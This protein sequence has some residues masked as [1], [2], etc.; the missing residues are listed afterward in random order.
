MQNSY[1]NNLKVLDISQGVAGPFGAKLLGDLGADVVKIEPPGGDVSRQYGPFPGGKAD[2]EQSAS[3]FFFNTSK[4]GMVLDIDSANGKDTLARLVTEYDVIIAGESEEVL[5]R[6]GLSYADFCRWNPNIILT[7]V[8]GFGSFGPHSGYQ[9][10]HLVASA[11]GGWSTLCGVPDREPLQTGGA[12]SETLAG[13]FA[14]V[15]TSMAVLG[16]YAHGRGEHVDVSVQE[17]VLAC[18]SFPTL[19][20]EYHGFTRDRYSSVGGG[21]GACYMIPTREGYI[22]LN[23]LTVAQWRMLCRFLG[24]EDIITDPH[25][26][27]VSW[28]RPDERLEEIREAFG[29]AV[30]DRT[31]EEL[32]H[33]AQ[34]H[35]VPFG[36]VPDL[37]K[38]FT[39]PPFVERGFFQKISHPVTGPVTIPGIPFNVSGRDDKIRIRRPPLLGEHHDE[40]LNALKAA[41]TVSENPRSDYPNPLPLK[42]LRVIDLSMFFAGPVCTQILADAGADVIKVESVQR[43]DGWRGSVPPPGSTAPAWESAPHFNWVNR[44]KRGITL[45]LTDP[46]GTE[47]LKRL[48]R[49]ADVVI[50]N[51][52]PRVMDKFGLG[53][54]I[55]REIKPDIIMI[56]LPGF[57]SDVT[58]RDYV[59][60]GMST[61]QMSG[62]AHLTGYNDDGPLFTG[63][64][65]GDIY[66]GAMGAHL[67]LAALHDRRT[68]G[69]G[70]HINLSQAEACNLYVGDAM[71]GYSLT[72]V[73][74]GRRGNSHTLFA[75]QGIYPCRN[76]RWI[77]ISCLT[78]GQWRS[79][80]D[81]INAELV[82]RFPDVKARQT[83]ELDDI[84]RDWTLG[85]D[86]DALMSDLQ[87]LG[88]A[89]GIVQNGPDLLA[90]PQLAT[91]GSLLVQDRPGIGEKHYPNQPY[92][93]RNAMAPPNE[94]APLLGEHCVEV[95]TSVAGVSDEELGE[96]F[97]DD[98]IGMDPVASR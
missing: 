20:Y 31:A 30:K 93:F 45:N 38:V 77:G 24:R 41:P 67:V 82:A 34:S 14:A 37:A 85:H 8:S 19:T 47:I 35:R 90:D 97:I 50:E 33:E 69:T 22:G 58:W 76:D 49:D 59:A 21:A 7:T 68:T 95:L 66:S 88:I 60:F 32:F 62:L 79:L 53:F 15:A 56:S 28:N 74:P 44:N 10:S 3:F 72:G 80:A 96:L 11:M 65:G 5:S 98:V 18:A 29:E 92:R 39:L 9:S 57:G 2:P 87:G 70:Q 75:P 54:D 26:Q 81:L 4:R 89:A 43:I 36:L 84:I 52:T 63:T 27:G 6:R 48:V 12:T 91:R 55:L 61:E 71:T 94:R 51:Y 25:F 86:A 13:A 78:D 83:P 1:L 16:R 64:T 46:R 23:A 17:A 40:I 42:G 73:D